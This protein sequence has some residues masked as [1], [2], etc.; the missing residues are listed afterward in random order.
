[1][2]ARVPVLLSAFA[3]VVIFGSIAFVSTLVAISMLNGGI[4]FPGEPEI[5]D[6]IGLS[7]AALRA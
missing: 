2:K 7:V 3:C 4:D 5:A 6:A 1:M